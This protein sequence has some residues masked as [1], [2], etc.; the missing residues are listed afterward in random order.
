M[1]L[2][3]LRKKRTYAILL[4]VFL[5]LLF[6]S[7]DWLGR[8]MYPIEYEATIRGTA[9][10]EQV[11][12]LFIASIIR[13]ESNYV[14][15]KVSSKGAI[16]LMQIM[17]STADWVAETSGIAPSIADQ[18]AEPE[19]NIKIGARYVRMLTKQY[20]DPL[21]DRALHHDRIALIAAAYNAGPGSVN[22]WLTNGVWSGTYDDVQAIPYGETRH[23]VRRII[24]YY[25]KYTEF[26]QQGDTSI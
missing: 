2:R 26:Y 4:I 17:P 1:S 16:G 11:D 14:P 21:M 13:V 10:V 25:E 6:A 23:F 19:L 12:P 5:I 3:L 9:E 22:N 18:L 20:A 24:Y 8:L 7:T 15:D